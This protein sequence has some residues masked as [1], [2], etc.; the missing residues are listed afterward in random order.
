MPRAS[1]ATYDVIV[2][3]ARPAGA[4]TAMLLARAG[5]RVL[6]VERG[7][8]GSDTVSTHALLR[9]GVLQ[10]ARWGL[11]DRIIAAGTPPVRHSVFHYG[12]ECVDV[13]IKPGGLVDA[14]YAPRRTVLDP[15]LVDAAIEAGAEVRFGVSVSGLRHDRQGRVNG[16]V[17]RDESGAPLELRARVTV[18]ADGL[19]SAVA[20]FTRAPVIRTG[21]SACAIIYG[22]WGGLAVNGYELFYRP[23]VAAGFFPTNAGQT[24]IFV[25]T[26]PRRFRRESRHGVA[27]AYRRM[28]AEVAPELVAGA[29]GAIGKAG[30]PTRLHVF[31]GRRP[32]YLRQ[33]FGPG[34]ALVGDA[35]YYKDP[36]TSHGLTDALR[37]AE[38]LAGAL[39]AAAT[40][41]ADEADAL[42]DYQETRD[43][44]SDRLFTVT[45]RIASFDWDL[46]RIP[47][48]LLQLSE[49][50]GDEVRHLAALEPAQV[51][52]RRRGERS[53]P[54][55]TGESC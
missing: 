27:H 42:A 48:L 29:A 23:G 52:V 16:I 7:Q 17:G 37:D 51:G 53:L 1:P 32:G 45:D 8:Y 35:G 4:A 28:L 26:T 5:L 33:A 41:G 10:L 14:L 40:G 22:Y 55:T 19:G 12:H 38:L 6:V 46:K 20:R 2:V 50:M 31:A 3:G 15:I 43:Q 47:T 18:G 9:G 21:G 39:T 11:L 30:W 44:L 34:W 49:S 24:C 54:V 13:P 36:I 25:G